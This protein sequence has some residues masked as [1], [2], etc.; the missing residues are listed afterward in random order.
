MGLALLVGGL[1]PTACGDGPA[2]IC[3]RTEPVFQEAFVDDVAACATDRPE[4]GSIDL[5]ACEEATEN[6]SDAEL[7]A[8]STYLDCTSAV[9]RC[10]EPSELSQVE[11]AHE[12]CSAKL[13]ETL[14]LCSSD[15]GLLPF[16]LLT[17]EC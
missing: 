7:R 3:N 1:A 10:E 6:C 4:I 17:I 2:E 14:D 5:E 15:C 11:Q 12:L 16:G 8:Y 13:G 9:P